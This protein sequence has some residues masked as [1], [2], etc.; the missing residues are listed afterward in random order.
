[1]LLVVNDVRAVRTRSRTRSSSRNIERG[2]VAEHQ[3][4]HDVNLPPPPAPPPAYEPPSP[5]SNRGRYIESIRES[6]NGNPQ[7]GGIL[8]RTVLRYGVAVAVGSAI[9]LSG[10]QLKNIFSSTTPTTQS[11]TLDSDEIINPMN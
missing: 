7:R 4:L 10:V 3:S 2:S 6:N 11:N 1:M 8:A 9:G 5:L